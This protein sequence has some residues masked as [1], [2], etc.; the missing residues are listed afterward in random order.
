MAVN[1]LK[2]I[3]V[4]IGGKEITLGELAKGEPES[5]DGQTL[6]S[7]RSNATVRV[8]TVFD[9]NREESRSKTIQSEASETNINLI[10]ERAIKGNIPMINQREPRYGDFSSGFDYHE[11]ILRIKDYESNFE[12]LPSELR[13]RFDNDPAKLI[14]FASLPENEE[15]A[16]K[17]GILPKKDVVAEVPPIVVPEAPTAPVVP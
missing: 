13:A 10:I 2:D 9:T 4:K 7:R 12:R 5:F 8:A 15:E 11:N 16:I 14:D 1:P 6:V 3:K 17:L